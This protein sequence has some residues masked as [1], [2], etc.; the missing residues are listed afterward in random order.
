ME[1][2][3][4]HLVLVYLADSIMG[5]GSNLVDH[6]KG[7]KQTKSTRPT[8]QVKA[9]ACEQRQSADPAAACDGSALGKPRALD[10]NTDLRPLFT[11]EGGEVFPGSSRICPVIS[12]TKTPGAFHQ[13]KM[14]LIPQ[15]FRNKIALSKTK[16]PCFE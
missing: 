16:E 11:S 4:T 12:V 7:G 9:E 2:K 15:C 3:F 14:L 1:D 10:C 5:S 6:L 13:C 8:F